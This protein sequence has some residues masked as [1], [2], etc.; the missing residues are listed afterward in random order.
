MRFSCTDWRDW[1]YVEGV[2]VDSVPF[3]QGADV[4]LAAQAAC[5]NAKEADPEKVAAC[6]VS[7]A[8]SA[9]EILSSV[10]PGSTSNDGYAAL[11]CV[12]AKR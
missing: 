2:K 10:S 9:V 11:V 5:A 8:E 1:A 12:P 6:R 7:K 4:R 3:E